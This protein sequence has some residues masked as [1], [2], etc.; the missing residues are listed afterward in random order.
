MLRELRIAHLALVDEATLPLERGLTMLTGETGAGKSLVAGAL[1]LLAGGKAE[2]KLIREGE[3]LAWVEGVFDLSENEAA[4]G[5][6]GGLGVRVG[7]DGILVLRRELRREGRGR[8][9]INGL[10]SSQA[11]LEDIGGRLVAIQSQDQQRQL[12][13]PAFAREFL[14]AALGLESELAAMR[15]A[16]AEHQAAAAALAE[17]QRESDLAR[18]QQEMWEFQHRELVAM[19][20][21]EGE[22][23]KLDEDL[24]VGRNARGLLEAASRALQ[25]L[26]EGQPAAGELLGSAEKVLAP[27]EHTSARL[28]AAL[29][30][31]RDAEAAVGEAAADLR[32]FVDGL[33]VDPARLDEWEERRAQY[34]A[35]G[36]KYQRDVPGLIALRDELAQQLA[37]QRNADQD[38]RGLEEALRAAATRA[39]EAAL[40]LRKARRDGATAVARRACELVRPLALPDLEM[41]F[42]IEPD[43]YASGPVELD[44]QRCRVTGHGADQVRLRVRTNRGEAPG[45]IGAIASGGERSRIWLG[46]SVLADRQAERPLLLFDEID[47]GLGMDNAR[48]VASLLAQLAESRQVVCIT[49]LATV[50]VQGVRHWVVR[51]AAR[52]RRTVLAV[53]EVTGEERVQEVARL[54]GGSV[55]SAGSPAAQDAYARELLGGRATTPATGI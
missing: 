12:S 19:R 50:A 16:V 51:K 35:L 2:P 26:S 7:G 33:E 47:A 42:E 27:L 48:P 49:H 38:V 52:G 54:L 55:G 15:E 8:V 32:R 44:G 9:L 4:L 25:D 20:L 18:R 3:E 53:A 46:L 24:A 41:R 30:L 40:A 11:L 5:A 36:R 10:V 13:R 22:T 39:A 45:E 34:Q 21:R 6:C 31:V 23:D 14:D 43:L 29:R 28:G 1:S 17:R 37:R